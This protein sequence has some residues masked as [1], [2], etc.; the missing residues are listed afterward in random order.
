MDDSRLVLT[1]IAAIIISTVVIYYSLFEGIDGECTD[2]TD[3]ECEFLE[4]ISD[5]V[6]NLALKL[7]DVNN[8]DDSI[9][10]LNVGIV[11]STN[12]LKNDLGNNLNNVKHRIQ[13]GNESIHFWTGG[14]EYKKRVPEFIYRGRINYAFH[15]GK[16]KMFDYETWSDTTFVGNKAVTLFAE[17][18]PR[19]QSSVGPKPFVIKQIYDETNQQGIAGEYFMPALD[20]GADQPHP[21]RI[22]VEISNGWVTTPAAANTLHGQNPKAHIP[23]YYQEL[24]GAG[25]AGGINTLIVAVDGGDTQRYRH[26]RAADVYLQGGKKMDLSTANEDLAG[27][28]GYVTPTAA[29]PF[30]QTATTPEMIPDRVPMVLWEDLQS[31]TLVDTIKDGPADMNG[32]GVT[33]VFDTT[34]FKDQKIVLETDHDYP[35][36]RLMFNQTRGTTD[37]GDTENKHGGACEYILWDAYGGRHLRETAGGTSFKFT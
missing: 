26:M 29:D 24:W 12:Q 36:Y 19:G 35:F 37:Q 23:P 5:G 10:N 33:A 34:N 3:C 18:D 20:Y 8:I 17:Y 6:D 2:Q 15:Q 30:P 32:Y 21:H 27:D 11:N 4:E 28:A 14:N 22:R 31:R 25:G 7:T 16:E 1:L 9:D 13:K